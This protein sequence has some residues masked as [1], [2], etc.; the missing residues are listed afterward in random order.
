M[1]IVETA[2]NKPGATGEAI[3]W[4]VHVPFCTAKCRY[5]DFYSV[6]VEAGPAADFGRV[7]GEE[8]STRDPG[9][10]VA[11]VFVGG[12]TPTVLPEEV[13]EALL[14]SLGGGGRAGIEYTVEANP[15]SAVE[16]KLQLLRRLGVNRLSLGVQSFH[17]AELRLLGRLHDPGHIASSFAAARAAGFDNINLDLIY[18]IPGQTLGHWRESLHLAAELGPEHLSCYALTYEP[19]TPMTRLRQLGAIIPCGE[20]IEAGMFEDA[21]ERLTRAGY[22]HYE[23]SNFAKPGRRCRANM[24]Y[25]ENREY[26]GIGPSAVSYLGGVRRKN[27]PDVRRYIEVLSGGPG[28]IVEEE[29]RLSPEAS[30]CETAMQMLRL[31]EGI[32]LEGFRRRTGHD[33]AEFFAEPISRFVKEGLLEATPACV[34]L[35]RRGMLLANRVMVEFAP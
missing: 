1:S 28:E 6:P 13:L 19:H 29:E 15:A 23:I 8:L 7:A 12:G 11:S 17:A 3:G 24:I 5:C 26:L 31:T 20:E 9:R 10:P 32:N 25:W 14:A 16:M 35:T 18:G 33:A 21:I 27:I 2:Q 34:R 30:A 22:E 4:Y